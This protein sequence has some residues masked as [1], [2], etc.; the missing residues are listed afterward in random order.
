M[1]DFFAGFRDLPS[2]GIA[3]LIILVLYGVQAEIRFGN[4][5]RAM[6]AGAADR[7]SSRL[8][9][10]ASAIPVLAFVLAMKV[11]AASW[12][13]FLPDWF[14]AAVLPGMPATAWVGIALG[15]LGLVIR[16]WAVLTL[17]E[18]YSRTLL[19]HEQH[20][21]ERGGP[22]RWVRHPGY[23]G[24]LFTFNGVALASGNWL[25]LVFSFVVTLAA[26]TYRISVED[27]MLVA[28]LGE[29]YAEYRRQVRALI[30]SLRPAR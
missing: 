16:L 23:L 15:A 9:Y 21:I 26:Y 4:R 1:S 30:P 13:P 7:N 5:A 28:E 19:V 2:Y 12:R 22:Y 11:N 25:T 14:R 6:R 3:G 29:P 10:V 27:K 18:R 8:L 20:A 24:S 17:R